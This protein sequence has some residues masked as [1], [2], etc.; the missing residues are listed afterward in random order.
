MNQTPTTEWVFTKPQWKPKPIKV[1]K[2]SNPGDTC[3]HC[4]TFCILPRFHFHLNSIELTAYNDFI[5][6]F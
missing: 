3:H 5:F 4:I 6:K 1:F 2:K